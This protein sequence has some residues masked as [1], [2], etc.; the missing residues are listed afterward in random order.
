MNQFQMRLPVTIR[1]TLIVALAFFY[2]PF[3]TIFLLAQDQQ[4]DGRYYERE[5]IKAYQ[6]KDFKA[7]LENLKMALALRPN[8]PRLLYN[9]AGAYA[10]NGDIQ[11]ALKSLD[12]VAGMGL[13]YA[14]EKDEDFISIK[15]TDDFK[16]ILE[17]FAANKTP[18][19]RSKAVFAIHEKGLITESVAYDPVTKTFYVSSVRKRKIISVNAKGEAKDFATEKD[20]LWAIL[21]IKVDVRRRLLW[22]CSSSIPQM[23][24]FKTEDKGKS[25]V[26]KFDLKTGKL[27]KTY[28][29]N[30]TTNEHWLGD[31]V[32]GPNGDV[33][34]T[35][36]AKPTVYVIRNGKDEIEPF[37]EDKSFVNLQGL[38]FTPDGRHMFVADYAKGVFVVDM[39]TKSVRLLT[40]KPTMTLL[41]ID[42]LYFY[43]GNLV[44]TQ[45]GTN[46]QRVVRLVLNREM[47]G[48]E[49]VET[50][51]VNHPQHDEITLGLVL[52][53]S[54]YYIAN[55]QWWAINEKGELAAEE[56][57]KE[58]V[59]LSFGL[60]F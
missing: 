57:L 5:A 60:S 54:F 23:I 3:T 41:G 37:L 42:G 24:N 55:S 36:S 2:L 20:G 27:L 16:K 11:K 35:D 32:V 15:D 48:V 49:R 14:A 17:K 44:A 34:A 58:P 19:V 51:E 45:N 39:K 38:D 9:I 8:H 47:N 52:N 10:L 59:V 7:Y 43:K 33:F 26:L 1:K 31:L 25:A 56:K 30:D 22:A 40:T 28:L 18:I 46:P 21:G 12:H 50:L 29:I 53:N 13:I 4:K 6:N